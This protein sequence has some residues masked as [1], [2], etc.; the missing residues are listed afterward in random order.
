V[1][2]GHPRVSCCIPGCTRGTTRIEQPE[3]VIWLE[4]GTADPGWMCGPHWRRVPKLLKSRRR[5]LITHW[6]GLLRRGKVRSLWELPP[7]SPRRVRAVR[8]ERLI[9]AVWKRCV[10]IAS[11]DDRVDDAG[12][13]PGLQEELRRAGL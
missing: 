3:G 8:S 5:L 6:R 10:R 1:T 11:G 13:P 9:R 2:S 12:L 4:T 7:G